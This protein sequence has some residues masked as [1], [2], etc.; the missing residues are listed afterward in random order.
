[1]N[2]FHEFDETCEAPA[3]YDKVEHSYGEFCYFLHRHLDDLCNSQ[4]P[5]NLSGEDMV[6]FLEKLQKGQ[7][8]EDIAREGAELIYER[9]SNE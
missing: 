7:D 6:P 4:A 3:P 2:N 5:A 8:P 1:M 9:Y